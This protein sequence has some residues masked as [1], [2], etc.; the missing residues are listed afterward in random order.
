MLWISVAESQCQPARHPPALET[1]RAAAQEHYSI[2]ESVDAIIEVGS[3]QPPADPINSPYYCVILF[4]LEKCVYKT[5]FLCMKK[6]KLPIITTIQLLN[7][8]LTAGTETN[9]VYF[10]SK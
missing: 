2:C 1:R 3:T 8:F 7:F 6:A 10:S 9:F 5:V 4:S